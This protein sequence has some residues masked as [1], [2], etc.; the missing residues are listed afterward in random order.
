MTGTDK[1]GD[2]K[3]EILNPA[4]TLQGLSADATDRAEAQARAARRA[5]DEQE[6]QRHDEEK[7]R[8]AE[9]ERALGWYGR[10][11]RRGF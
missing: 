4:D 11:W 3:R 8:K 7:K 9:A 2:G 10:L 6:R 5:L 1:P